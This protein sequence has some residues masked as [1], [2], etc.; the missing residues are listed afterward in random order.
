VNN[1]TPRTDQSHTLY[2]PVLPSNGTSFT[3]FTR[4]QLT[5]NQRIFMSGPVQMSVTDPQDPST[6]IAVN[7]RAVPPACDGLT[8][9]NWFRTPIT[10]ELHLR[11]DF[12]Q[13]TFRMV[14]EP[15]F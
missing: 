7:H 3:G 10:P 15:P 9:E 11:F 6:P 1:T 8:H 5:G 13:Q 4:G 2:R 12:G 14:L